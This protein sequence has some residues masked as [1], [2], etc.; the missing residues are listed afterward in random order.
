MSNKGALKFVDWY[1]WTYKYHWQPCHWLVPSVT[2]IL[3]N[4]LLGYNYTPCL[5]KRP[6]FGLL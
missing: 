3:H 2:T 1:R 5:K 4:L 6:T